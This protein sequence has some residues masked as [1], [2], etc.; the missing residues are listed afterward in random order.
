MNSFSR[1]MM[2]KP[3]MNVKPQPLT[4][5]G[6]TVF[7]IDD[8]TREITLMNKY[9]QVICRLHFRTSEYAILDRFNELKNNLPAILEPLSRIDLNPD[10]SAPDQDESWAVLKEV[11]G[12]IKRELN[13]LLDM[14]EAD[15][16]FK[17]RSP[18]S[19]VNGKYFVLVVLDALGEAI[20]AAI[21]EE[22]ALSEARLQKYMN[23]LENSGEVTADA[24][25]ASDEP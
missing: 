20:G 14:T 8:G 2:K 22:T 16:I 13:K 3:P 17:T 4:P 15:E 12:N 5:N 24:G 19:S 1:P 7:E 25:D 11:E 23:D 10:G 21:K 6:K 18:F 9:G